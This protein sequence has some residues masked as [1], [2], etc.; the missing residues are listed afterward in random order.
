MNN[1]SDHEKLDVYQRYSLENSVREFAAGYIVEH[2]N[3]HDYE[4]N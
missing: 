1:I 2:E 3:E 4:N